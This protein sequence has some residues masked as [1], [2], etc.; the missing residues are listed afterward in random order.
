MWA[1]LGS[2]RDSPRGGTM[3]DIVIIAE[4]KRLP[5]LE[6]YLRAEKEVSVI[7]STDDVAK[8]N[9][10]IHKAAVIVLEV[11]KK[12]AKLYILEL[13]SKK[14]PIVVITD[15]ATFGFTMMEWGATEMQLRYDN[16]Q[17]SYF[18][19][20]LAEKIKNVSKKIGGL[21][22]RALKWPNKDKIDKIIVIGSSTGG[23]ETVEY[24]LKQLPG[25]IPPILLVQHMPPIFT[26]MF[27]ERLHSVCKMSVWEAREGD[28]LLNGLA[29]IAPGDYHMVLDKNA[30]GLFVRCTAG[31]R[32]CN[33]RPSV[34]V[35]FESVAK[36]MGKNSDKAIGI[37]LTGMGSDGAKGLLA[38][39]S[40]GSLTIGQNKESCVVYGMPKAAFESGAVDKQLH[41]NDIASAILNFVKN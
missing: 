28:F 21:T 41:L 32:V 39:R 35:L 22:P 2:L 30:E 38:M 11:D 9:I 3:I 37:I 31:E 7:Y 6:Q 26:R 19:K 8:A 36:V 16:Q 33:Q 27:A 24:I 12:D 40:K 20:L 14:V 18:Y 15:S 34:D 23:T 1:C 4:K 5:E 17:K 25:N 13:K 29:L 10:H